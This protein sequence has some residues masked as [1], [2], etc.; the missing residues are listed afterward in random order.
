MLQQTRVELM[1]FATLAIAVAALVLAIRGSGEAAV[2]VVREG[3]GPGAVGHESPFVSKG[4]IQVRIAKFTYNPDPI[5]VQ[6]G[7][8]IAWTNLDGVPHTVTAEDMSWGSGMMGQNDAFGFVF[9]EPGVYTYICALHPPLLTLL[10]G[11]S[12]GET[13]LGGGGA[14]MQGKIIV[15]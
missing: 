12:A 11:G 4:D 2:T 7:E 9:D 10:A 15:E 8:Q 6:V 5:R 3:S 1:L 13:F 14:G